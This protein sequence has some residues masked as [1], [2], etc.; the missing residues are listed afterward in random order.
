ME[1]K[2]TSVAAT[3]NFVVN[4]FGQSGLKMFMDSLPKESYVIFDQSILANNWY[5]FND[6]FVKPTK[7]IC[8]L[9]FGGSDLGAREIGKFS[10]E[11]SLKG[12]YR[13]F[14]RVA[15]VGFIMERT[16]SIFKTYYSPGRMEVISRD[17]HRLVFHILDTDESHPLFEQRICGWIKGALLICNNRDHKVEISKS[18][19]RGDGL[20]EI[21][22]SL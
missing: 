3:K 2:G 1:V 9:F 6:A 19:T 8:D 4:K 16:A 11:Q 14:A 18:T 12:I 21:V 10:A 7:V 22:V 15:S 17:E 13:T 5:P 20:T